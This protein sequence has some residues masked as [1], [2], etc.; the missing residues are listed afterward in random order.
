MYI[1]I[2]GEYSIPDR[3]II[4]IFDLD[5]VTGADSCTN[6]F[7]FKAEKDGIVETVSFDLPRSMI[8]TLERVYISPISAGTIR[9]RAQKRFWLN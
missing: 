7:L 4:G 5:E 6:D 3:T 2:G 9:K 8:V 1:H